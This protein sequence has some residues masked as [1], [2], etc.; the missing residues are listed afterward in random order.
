MSALIL[1]RLEFLN[2]TLMYLI[3]EEDLSWQV[4]WRYRT[5]FVE[6][7][8][9]G[10]QFEARSS[11]D[12]EMLKAWCDRENRVVRL[13]VLAAEFVKRVVL[14]K[15]RSLVRDFSG[16]MNAVGR[17]WRRAVQ[18]RRAVRRA[19]RRG[20][21]RAV[22]RARAGEVLELEQRRGGGR[23]PRRGVDFG[24]PLGSCL[25]QQQRH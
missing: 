17:R 21:R 2:Q 11:L 9:V 22:R 19:V 15:A 24:Q 6:Q 1:A 10:V 3:L 16:S 7:Y 8:F 12:G 5:L 20:E 25:Q 23:G 13:R 18:E 14:E 4:V